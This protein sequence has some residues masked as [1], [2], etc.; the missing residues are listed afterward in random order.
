MQEEKLC[1][2]LKPILPAWLF[3]EKV[4]I[5]GGVIVE[6]YSQQVRSGKIARIEVDLA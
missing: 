3:D 5:D 4:N 2:E 1:L 6:P